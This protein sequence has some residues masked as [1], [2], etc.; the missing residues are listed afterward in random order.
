[1]GRIE[2]GGAG[3]VRLGEHFFGGQFLKVCGVP[4][5]PVILAKQR[6]MFDPFTFDGLQAILERLPEASKNKAVGG[7]RSG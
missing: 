5:S 7:S 4:V 6:F 1:M 2:M 3:E